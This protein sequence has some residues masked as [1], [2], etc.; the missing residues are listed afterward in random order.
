MVCQKGG[1]IGTTFFKSYLLRDRD[2]NLD[3]G[4]QCVLPSGYWV[5]S[6]IV[7]LT[8]TMGLQLCRQIICMLIVFEFPLWVDFWFLI[9]I[10]GLVWIMRTNG[11]PT[12][13]PTNYQFFVAGH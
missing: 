5:N 1:E 12:H 6:R 4:S 7:P 3:C 9:V 8:L 2:D 11:R 13:V 10:L